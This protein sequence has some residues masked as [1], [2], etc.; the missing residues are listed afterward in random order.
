[1]S[2]LSSNKV[3]QINGVSKAFSGKFV[4]SDISL[5]VLK[6]ETVC[7]LGP[8]G[9]GKST[10]L[11]CM[12]WLEIPDAGSIYV[13]GQRIGVKKDSTLK[14]SDRELATIRAKIGMV[15]QSFAL[16]PHLSVL[17]NVTLAPIQVL[18]RDPVSTKKFALELLDKV[19]LLDKANSFP[20]KLS[21]GQKQRVGI[22]RALAMNPDVLLLDEPTSALDPMLVGEVLGVIQSLA[23]EGVTMVIVTH[24][25]EF[26]KQVASKVVFMD[27]G[28][29]EETST[30]EVFF[31]APQT[32][33]AKKFLSR[34]NSF[35]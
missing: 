24:E 10:L 16:W 20:S 15:F 19:G 17:E 13:S 26:A 35:Q 31:H 9:C 18:R 21:G 2:N 3:L 4:L 27:A 28:H 25:M 32:E 1:M 33:K 23:R 30:P 5:D 34:F 11:R 29:I 6:G 12:N 22:A 7:L 8:S 14:M